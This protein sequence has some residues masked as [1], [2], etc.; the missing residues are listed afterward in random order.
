M[1]SI[2]KFQ[3][4]DCRNGYWYINDGDYNYLWKDGTI[5]SH[6]TGYNYSGGSFDTAPGYWN[7]RESA[8][9]FLKTYNERNNMAAI[10]DRI[11]Q[12][13]IDIARLK[14][15][16]DRLMAEKE[17]SEIRKVRAGDVWRA[18]SETVLVIVHPYVFRFEDKYD[19]ISVRKDGTIR[20]W[21]SVDD[22][23]SC[24]NCTYL[25]NVNE[26]YKLGW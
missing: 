8:E 12:C 9:K 7:S 19:F 26:G 21:A 14:D 18:Y 16:L 3:V 23:G 1:T 15:N 13:N 11:N 2:G 22:Y 24:P 4:L 17:A 6:T 5:H 10:D 20:D 25:G